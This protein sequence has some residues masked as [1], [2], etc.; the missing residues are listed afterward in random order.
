MPANLSSLAAA[1]RKEKD[2][3]HH[4]PATQPPHHHRDRRSALMTATEQQ[5]HERANPFLPSSKH[6][7]IPS[8]HPHFGGLD[9]PPPFAGVSDIAP[10]TP[11]SPPHSIHRSDRHSSS[12]NKGST[13]SHHQRHH[14]RT[15]KSPTMQDPSSLK[16]LI[17]T[18]QLHTNY[19]HHP[20]LPHQ[21]SHHY[22]DRRLSAAAAA[23]I[24]KNSEM[25]ASLETAKDR[26]SRY[27]AHIELDRAV[28]SASYQ[29]PLFL[30]LQDRSA[31]SAGTGGMYPPPEML[32]R[33]S[34]KGVRVPRLSPRGSNASLLRTIDHAPPSCASPYDKGPFIDM[35]KAGRV[36]PPHSAPRDSS[37]SRHHYEQLTAAERSGLASAYAPLPPFGV[38]PRVPSSVST[39]SLLSAYNMYGSGGGTGSSHH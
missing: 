19:H 4:H 35:D 14:R 28:A 13:G 27:P 30:D 1:Y 36:L 21:R 29:R 24:I 16:S 6:S 34:D 8:H 18:T 5:H 33:H 7:S 12:T 22:D 32:N 26:L 39:A 11:R 38:Q 2:S 17:G 20:H 9:M 37:S 25:S 15:L 3:H 23:D 10:H 31:R